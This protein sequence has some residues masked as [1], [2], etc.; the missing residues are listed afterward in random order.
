LSR[1]NRKNEIRFKNLEQALVE[2]PEAY[3][4]INL[5]CGGWPCQDNSIAGS[6]AGHAG[7]K[8]GLWTEFR[9]LA[10]LFR[11]DWIVGENVP[12]LFSVNDG[13]DFWGVISDLDA[14]GYC[15]AWA[16]L[17]SQS[18]GVPQRRRRIFIVAS[19]GN[20]GAA[21]VL[22]E[23]PGDG[24]DTKE[25]AQIEPVGLCISARDGTRGDPSTETI[26]ANP[27]MATDYGRTPIGRFGNEGNLIAAYTITTDLRG[28]P[29]HI[30]NENLVAQ[31][32]PNGERTATGLPRGL[33]SARG[34][35]IGNAVTVPVAE[36][37]GK[38]I[39]KYSEEKLF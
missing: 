20:I 24:G 34:V 18:F 28:C 27:I 26:I 5:L 15:V 8:S 9:R 12:G 4:H 1:A 14:L 35:I 38:R 36:W 13:K 23:S 7:E 19:F 17:D 30:T 37:I 29:R 21:K 2:C 22:F 39:M 6:R 33:D 11:P 16:V 32:D 3:G 31:I 25:I 10:E